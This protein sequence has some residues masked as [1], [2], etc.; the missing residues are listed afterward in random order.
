MPRQIRV[1]FASLW[2][3]PWCLVT[4]R[5]ATCK[6][7]I[8]RFKPAEAAWPQRASEACEKT[9]EIKLNEITFCFYLRFYLYACI[10]VFC[11]FPN[12]LSKSVGSGS[13]CFALR[14][15][16]LRS[17][18]WCA[19]ARECLKES[20]LF[21]LHALRFLPHPSRGSVSNWLPPQA[22]MEADRVN[23]THPKYFVHC[24]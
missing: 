4:R 11:H 9:Y 19:S 13:E 15:E 2:P 21:T 24:L 17:A 10:C 7:A 6:F 22:W 8:P 23:Q 16:G 18:C 20:A 12:L 1:T 3:L 5:R 14:A